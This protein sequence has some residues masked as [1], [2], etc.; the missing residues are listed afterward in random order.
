[1]AVRTSAELIDQLK[2]RLGDDVSDEALS[3]LEDLTDTMSDYDRRISESGDWERRYNENDANWRQ[4][5]R[6]RFE[7]APSVAMPED[8]VEFIPGEAE[9]VVEEDNG[10]T[11]YEE[12][13][14]EE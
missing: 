7:N 11:T 4:R 5:Y 14:K 3:M 8:T 6:E 2:N 10:P 13:F 1:M 9:V 12:L